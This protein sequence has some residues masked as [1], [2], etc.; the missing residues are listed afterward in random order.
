MCSAEFKDI[1]IS[2]LGD[3]MSGNSTYEEALGKL[4]AIEQESPMVK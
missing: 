1:A 4:W 2:A 3:C